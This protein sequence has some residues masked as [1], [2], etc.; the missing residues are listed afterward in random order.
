M[1]VRIL[2]Y[3]VPFAINFL[4]GG[5]FFITA[6]RFAEAKFPATTVGAAVTAW[7]I[8]YC[9]VTLLIGRIAKVYNALGLI[10][11]G[12]I[13]LV[14][15]SGGFIFTFY[16]NLY[17]QFV[18]LLAAGCGAALFCTP[19]Q[20]L[21]KSI[22]SGESAAASAPV[23][24]TAFY[25][26]TWSTGFA[27]GPLAFARLSAKT[28]FLITLILALA[29]TVSV[30]LIAILNRKRGAED[31]KPPSESTESPTSNALKF[32]LKTFTIL[33]ILGW[34]V[35][36]LGTITVSQIRTMFP[37]RGEELAISR[38]HIA[39]VLALVSY[40]Q[41]FTALALCKSKCWMWKRLPA[42]L[43]SGCGIA[44][45]LLFALAGALPLFY[46][47]ALLYGIYSGCLYFY[48][49]YHSLAHPVR[50]GFFVAGNEVIVG[51]T[52][53]VSPLLGGLLADCTGFTGAAFIFAAV[54]TFAAFCAQLFLLKP[55][56]LEEMA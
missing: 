7:G 19:F 2:A 8:A 26:F 6:H 29:V 44:G 32:S 11:A 53:M 36:G 23:K 49:V 9:L 38:D 13:L 47:A 28:G 5:F 16:F 27:S 51:I 48:L 52:S 21:A 25:T 12:G 3:F 41:A 40:V 45:L 43:M 15:T 4:N 24:A 14:V 56:K 10:L 22:E 55:H 30:L 1:L 54:M 37:K 39:Y 18:W 20:L 17:W 31:I 33:A 34:I 35:G 42:L 46:L 50:S